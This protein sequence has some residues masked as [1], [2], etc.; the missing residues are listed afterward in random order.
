[1]LSISGIYLE[2]GEVSVVLLAASF[3]KRRFLKL[4]VD[5]LVGRNSWVC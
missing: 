5:R 1:M 3:S 4:L 2:S